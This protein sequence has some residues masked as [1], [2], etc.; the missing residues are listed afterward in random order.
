[1]HDLAEQIGKKLAEA[2][3][4]G[5]WQKDIPVHPFSSK[6]KAVTVIQYSKNPHLRSKWFKKLL[7][8][9]CHFKKP[10]YEN[11]FSQAR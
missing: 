9:M 11:L 8:E 4:M 6:L 2:E 3:N 1:M 10:N 7:T 5:M